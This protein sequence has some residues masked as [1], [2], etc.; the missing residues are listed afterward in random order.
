MPAKSQAQR[1]MMCREA[2]KPGST[3]ATGISKKSAAEFCHT[4]GK[5]QAKVPA[6]KK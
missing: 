1:A 4:P 2:S 5:L 6:K 3:K